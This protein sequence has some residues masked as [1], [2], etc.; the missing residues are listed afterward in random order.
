MAGAGWLAAAAAFVYAGV[1]LDLP[2]M[3]ANIGS[4][5]KDV[6]QKIAKPIGKA[7]GAILD[8]F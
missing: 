3:S 5:I 4:D 1:K 8:I 7:A 2:D 6:G